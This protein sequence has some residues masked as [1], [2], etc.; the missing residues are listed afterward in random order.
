MKPMVLHVSVSSK[1]L[2]TDESVCQKKCDQ[3]KD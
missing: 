2:R 1:N 3:K